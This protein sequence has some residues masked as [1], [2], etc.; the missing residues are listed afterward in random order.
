VAG[1][2][3]GSAIL[4]RLLADGVLYTEGNFYFIEPEAMSTHLGVSW[5][6]LRKG[7]ATDKLIQY[8]VAVGQA[9]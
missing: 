4:K 8:L 1:N 9:A 6:D 2:V 3:V 7:A 5:S